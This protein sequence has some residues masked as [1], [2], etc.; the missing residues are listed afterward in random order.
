MVQKQTTFEWVGS[1]GMDSDQ[2]DNGMQ[3]VSNNDDGYF[4]VEAAHHR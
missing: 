1:S 3:V 4:Q 2:L